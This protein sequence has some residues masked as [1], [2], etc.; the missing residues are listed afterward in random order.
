[1]GFQIIFIKGYGFAIPRNEVPQDILNLLDEDE[2]S[3]IENL[4]IEFAIQGQN[5][6]YTEED[7]VFFYQDGYIEIMD[8]MNYKFFGDIMKDFALIDYEDSSSEIIAEIVRNINNKELKEY[9]TKNVD[10]FG[11]GL[12][13]LMG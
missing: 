8:S 5:Y 12:V 10:K 3:D 4:G 11:N 2:N 6:G 13:S 9:L 1:M 7:I